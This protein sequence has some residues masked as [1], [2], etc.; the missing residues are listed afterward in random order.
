MN[1]IK[2]L[3]KSF[4]Y[5]FSGILNCIL[6][7]RNMRIHCVCVIYMYSFLGLTDW[8]VLSRADWAILFL[9]NAIV[10]MGELIN[11]AVEKT[12]D[13]VTA[14]RKPLAKI[15]KDAA[16]GAVLVGAIFAVCVGIAILGQKDAFVKMFEYFSANIPALAAF[17]VSFIIA[18]VFML[19]GIPCASK[20]GNKSE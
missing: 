3:F 18:S 7:E 11:T 20:K 16:A 6:T 5:A 10:M 8:F 19:K 4:G 12:V 13:L 17:I 9:A 2:N 15:A 14:E 1:D